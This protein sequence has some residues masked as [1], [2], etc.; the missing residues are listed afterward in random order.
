[1]NVQYW[2]YC[3]GIDDKKITRMKIE[4]LVFDGCPNG[5]RAE[6][7]VRG[8]LGE[9]GIEANKEFIKVVNNDDAVV[10]RFLGS[11]SIR[12]NGHDI[13][14]EE[15][16]HT[17]YSIGCRIYGRGQEISGVPH[18]DILISEIRKAAKKQPIDI[19]NYDL[20]VTD[21]TNKKRLYRVI[22]QIYRMILTE[23]PRLGRGP[24]V[25]ELHELLK[26]LNL[27][28]ILN[29]LDEL[30]QED[31]IVRDYEDGRIVAAYPYSSSETPHRVTFD[32]G[33][34]VW[35]MCAIDAL[36]IHFMTGQDITIDSTSP[37]SGL[38]VKIRMESGKALNVEP[39]D[40]VVWFAAK[41][42]GELH[43]AVTSCPG[44][45]FY[46]RG[47]ALWECKQKAGEKN[48]ELLSLSDAIERSNRIFGNLLN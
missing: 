26:H 38:P 1:M 2:N 3:P 31:A 6:I 27:A 15:N 7:L 45:N 17:Q 18:K 46:S 47:E 30:E 36:G 39:S 25:D 37:Q 24:T 42:K 16:E 33:T 48:G 44:T 23:F 28:D 22:L 41:K 11:P 14:I 35:A 12:I 9:L 13:E 34:K 5:A 4:L 10:K 21:V 32:N 19:S 20:E 40:V 8:I 43:D 29:A